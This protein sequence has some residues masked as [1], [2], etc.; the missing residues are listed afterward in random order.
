VNQTRRAL[1]AAAAL[2]TACPGRLHAQ[3][4]PEP[5]RL[6]LIE[7]LSGPFGNAG[8]AVFR[9]L[10]MAVEEVNRRGG[11]RLPGGPRPMALVR[12]DSKGSTE[13]AV[14]MLRGAIDQRIGFVMQ[15]NGSAVAAA[16]IDAL[17]KHNAREPARRALFLNYS[18]V[19]PSLTHERCSF[20]HFR[21]DAHADMRLVALVDALQA[22]A[23]V[24]RVYLFNQ[25][26]SLGQHVQRRARELIAARRPDIAF[27]GEELH[28]LGR[29]RDFMPYATKIKASGAQAV[30]TANWGN[31]LTLL[32]RALRE[33]GSDA[34]LYTFYGN[35]LGAPAAIGADGV[36]RIVAVAEW[37]P[38]L[39][40]AASDAFYADFRR[41]YPEP[42]DDWAAVRQQLMVQM[43]ATAIEAARSTEAAAVARA[44]EG[45]TSAGTRFEGW[46]P[47][48]MRAADHQLQQPLV[49]VQ[50]DRAGTPGVPHDVEGSGFGFRTLRRHEPQAMALP[51]RCRML[52]PEGG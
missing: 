13:E 42:A 47:A 9:N 28:P 18:A 12:F 46:H 4:A 27:V 17:D 19:E 29:V 14:S 38:N 5:I 31:D 37:H 32:V 23:A 52:R 39:G 50:M 44:L 49:V 3:R 1:L 22:D 21:F 10:L 8:E 33:V 7:G 16:L 36:G 11:V 6:A 43:L 51:H 48:E 34:R 35:A 20:W 24:Q 25:D 26:Y 45:A 30:L 40:G 15:G 2:A 41:R